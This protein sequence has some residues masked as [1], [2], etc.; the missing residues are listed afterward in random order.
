ML[1]VPDLPC[2]CR[3]PMAGGTRQRFMGA[4]RRQAHTGLVRA[5]GPRRVD[6]QA[7]PCWM[8]RSWACR[9]A[10]T[11]FGMSCTG[12]SKVASCPSRALGHAASNASLPRTRRATATASAALPPALLSS[13]HCLGTEACSPIWSRSAPSQARGSSWPRPATRPPSSFGTP[14]AP[15]PSRKLS[16]E[17]PPPARVMRERLRD[18]LPHP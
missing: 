8:L 17:P 6:S 15:Q 4:T 16:L 2:G 13:D 10:T 11:K 1:G 5:R 12:I 14:E 7:R 9:G 3:M 18:A